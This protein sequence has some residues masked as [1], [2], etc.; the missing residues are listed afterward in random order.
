MIDVIQ[1]NFMPGKVARI[2]EKKP[3]PQFYSKAFGTYDAAV[4]DGLNTTTQRQ[5]QFAQMLQLREV[6]VPITDEDLLHASTMQNKNELVE[7][8]QKRQQE[9]AKV[10]QA[11]EQA[12]LQEQQARI[13]LAQARAIADRGLGIERV[14]RVDENH[15]LA[16]ERRSEAVKDRM[17]GMLDIVKALKEMDDIDLRQVHQLLALANI[18]KSQETSGQQEGLSSARITQGPVVGSIDRGLSSRGNNLA[19]RGRVGGGMAALGFS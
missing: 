19:G 16:E 3:S 4:E 9:A 2:I 1:A 8:M 15:A 10:K 14:S 7:N 12:A 11:Q 13:E 6:G 18:V 5:M 17:S